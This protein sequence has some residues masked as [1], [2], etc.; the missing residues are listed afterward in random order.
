M[1]L[2]T[3]VAFVQSVTKEHF[4]SGSMLCKSL[5]ISLVHSMIP[6]RVQRNFNYKCN[7]DNAEFRISFSLVF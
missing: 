5:S 4:V 6:R 3:F 2:T 7:E 1:K